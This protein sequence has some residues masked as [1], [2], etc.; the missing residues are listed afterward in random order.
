MAWFEENFGPEGPA[1]FLNNQSLSFVAIWAKSDASPVYSTGPIPTVVTQL[2]DPILRTWQTAEEFTSIERIGGSVYVVALSPVRDAR[3]ENPNGIILIGRAVGQAEA[4]LVR[5]YTLS[6][7]ALY[8][9][10]ALVAATS[11][12]NATD[13]NKVLQN[14]LANRE[15]LEVGN[16]EFAVAYVPIQDSTGQV[17]LTV[18]LWRSRDQ[19]NAAQ[20]AISGGLT[21]GL[22]TAVLA[23]LLGAALL[24]IVIARPLE[25][26]SHA[27]TRLAQGD[28]HQRIKIRR[29]DEIG[30][31]STAFNHMAERLHRR[32]REVEQ[33]SL[34][35]QQATEQRLSLFRAVA[36]AFQT[37]LVQ[38]YNLTQSLYLEMYGALNEVQRETVASIRRIINQQGAILKDLVDYSHAERKQ[39][40]IVKQR[41]SLVDIVGDVAGSLADRFTE[42]NVQLIIDL[43]EDLPALY[44]DRARMEQILEQLLSWEA[45][46]TVPNGEVRLNAERQGSDVHITVSD[47][48]GG[49]RPE[50]QQRIFD[51]FYYPEG[52][53]GESDSESP[54]GIGLALANALVEQQGGTMSIEVFPSKGNTFRITLPASL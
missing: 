11:S 43:A 36:T 46:L 3:A 14:T 2:A 20:A 18:V 48:S 27:A 51:L 54:V 39:L 8:R 33:D 28:Y 49:L 32:V 15:T 21:V 12:E 53:S 50:E 19:S 41:V 34:R 38:I 4:N 22:V 7:V 40:R 26:V 35:V 24:S 10:T 47:T 52:W 45:R 17:V 6:E 31:I 5:S 30:K 23:A 1:S 25:S 16:G 29:N 13:A 42:K 37:P 44:T 9:S